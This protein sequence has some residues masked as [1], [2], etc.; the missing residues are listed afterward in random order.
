M[1]VDSYDRFLICFSPAPSENL[2]NFAPDCL[3]ALIELFPERRS[4]T[5]GRGDNNAHNINVCH[6]FIE[7]SR[8]QFIEAHV[9]NYG[10][11]ELLPNSD[12]HFFTI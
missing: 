3:P 4:Q 12:D 1:L 7:T 9:L 5:E 11:I 10:K 6:H 2:I 8:V